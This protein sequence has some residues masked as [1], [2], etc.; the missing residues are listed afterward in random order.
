MAC[1]QESGG[2]CGVLA[3]VQA[4]L[5]CRLLFGVD[6]SAASDLKKPSGPTAG[7]ADLQLAPA[8]FHNDALAEAVAFVMW[9][10][11][12][13]KEHGHAFW[14]TCSPAEL[15]VGPETP[16]SSYSVTQC[17]SFTELSSAVAASI[18]DGSL[19]SS[20]GTMLLVYSLLL[21]RGIETIQKQDMDEPVPLVA[22]FGHCTQELLNLCLTGEAHSG[23][24][25][26]VQSL[27][28]E[29]EAASSSGGGGAGAGAGDVVCLKGIT[30]QPLVGYLSHIEAMRYGV[31]GGYYKQP[32]YPVWVIGSESHFTVIFGTDPGVNAESPSG[33]VYRAFK[34][35]DVHD[36]QFIAADK[37][38]AVLS[39]LQISLPAAEVEALVRRLDESSGG[40]GIVTWSNFWAAV[41]PLQARGEGKAGAVEDDL[42]MPALIPR[43]PSSST[44]PPSSSAAYSNLC[45]L[46]RM[47]FDAEDVDGGGFIRLG[48]VGQVVAR[49]RD[50][51]G[52]HILPD[53]DVDRITREVGAGQEADMAIVF[54]DQLQEAMEHALRKEADR[55]AAMA[56]AASGSASTPS[57]GAGGAGSSSSAASSGGKRG[58]SDSD[59][60][61]EL[62]AQLNSS[63]GA[64][65]VA[66]S[67]SP[68]GASTAGARP[69]PAPPASPYLPSTSASASAAAAAPLPMFDLSQFGLLPP[70]AASGA[71]TAAGAGKKKGAAASSSSSTSPA[72]QPREAQPR[73]AGTGAGG[74]GGTGAAPSSSS[75]T[76]SSYGNIRT[77]TLYHYNGL[78]D[79]GR[80]PR[81]TTLTIRQSD[82]GLPPIESSADHLALATMGIE[83]QTAAA[84]ALSTMTVGGGD[85]NGAAGAGAGSS[86]SSAAASGSGAPSS[87]P[88]TVSAH[89]LESILRTKWPACAMAYTG[90]PPTID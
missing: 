40:A 41:R 33:D 79:R 62:S 18:S 86:P 88:T 58:R 57:A 8:H 38:A 32:L 89:A 90:Q 70:P 23:I 66:A 85:G 53:T 15:P 9:Q 76:S 65:G 4:F 30:R 60:A 3:A 69:A 11:V 71:S 20:S 36:N 2:P 46:L 50:L 37:V 83:E 59:L 56:A 28:G 6:F 47:A 72:T 29:L 34:K 73:A 48:C 35:H 17:S 84:M 63:S 45:D 55:Q 67:G 80:R 44:T 49:L 87:S 7:V 74:D 43:E 42:P 5:A 22:R 68:S 39:D 27:G 26:G 10:C 52:A 16:A 61:R 54:Y 21:T 12:T 82:T 78:C 64:G 81:L 77:F 19:A 24:F 25:D 13:N 75:A 31:V 51:A 1:R 14:V